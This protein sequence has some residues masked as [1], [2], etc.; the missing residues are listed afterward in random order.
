L[1]LQR[2]CFDVELVY[3]AR[4]FRIPIAEENVAWVEVAGSKIRFWSILSMAFD[5]VLLKTAYLTGAWA[6]VGEDAAVDS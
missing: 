3:L 6:A 2:W 1:R 5:L 4:R